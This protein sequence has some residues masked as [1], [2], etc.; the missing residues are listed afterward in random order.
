M[1]SL[2]NLVGLRQNTKV[3]YLCPIKIFDKIMPKPLETKKEAPIWKSV[4]NY[5]KEV[6]DDR[7]VAMNIK[8]LEKMQ[9]NGGNNKKQLVKIA[10]NLEKVEE[11]LERNGYGYLKDFV[12]HY[13]KNSKDF[14]EMTS[15]SRVVTDC[16]AIKAQHNGI[17]PK[18][19]LSEVAKSIANGASFSL[20]KEANKLG[21]TM[22][23]NVGVMINQ[24]ESA[25]KRAISGTRSNLQNAG[26][27]DKIIDGNIMPVLKEKYPAIIGVMGVSESENVVKNDMITVIGHGSSSSKGVN[28]AQRYTEQQNF[29]KEVKAKI[30]KFAKDNAMDSPEAKKYLTEKSVEAIEHLKKDYDVGMSRGR[31][32]QQ[33][34]EQIE[35]ANQSISAI[36]SGETKQQ[37]QPKTPS[38]SQVVRE[39]QAI[40]KSS[41]ETQQVQNETRL[42]QHRETSK[43]E[44]VKRPRSKQLV[45]H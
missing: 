27:D 45:R 8:K 40:G 36:A 31:T 1:Y 5:F 23:T 43:G 42:A 21:Y 44:D 33:I 34:G 11:A 41:K 3:R 20:S 9:N 39:A 25:S 28:F 35:R 22:T 32:E 38:E 10:E 19:K 2:H 37:N 14:S 16:I 4:F 24:D 30:I 12:D 26:I 7:T 29:E 15:L 17:D 18:T 6:I 13:P